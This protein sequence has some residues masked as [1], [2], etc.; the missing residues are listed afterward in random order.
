[1]A[2]QDGNINKNGNN[3]AG[4]NDTDNNDDDSNNNNNSSNNSSRGGSQFE[5]TLD[6]GTELIT[7]YFD[8][9][10]APSP[11]AL[12]PNKEPPP[13][14]CS[15]P[16]PPTCSKPPPSPPP[17]CPA[18]PSCPEP[19][20]SC[21]KPE[22]TCSKPEP[23]CSKLEPT[24]SKPEP[25]CSKAPPSC[26]KK[27]G[28][29]EEKGLFER[30]FEAVPD[31][32][33][34]LGPVPT[35]AC[36]AERFFD[37]ENPQPKKCEK[38]TAK[39]GP[40]KESKNPFAEWFASQ[41]PCPN[42]P[43]LAPHSSCGAVCNA[44]PPPPEP[45]MPYPCCPA[46]APK[47]E[48]SKCANES[49]QPEVKTV[50]GRCSEKSI[51]NEN[52]SAMKIREELEEEEEEEERRGSRERKKKNTSMTTRRNKRKREEE[53]DD[54]DDEGEDEDED[55]RQVRKRKKSLKDTVFGKFLTRNFCGKSE[56]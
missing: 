28:C 13:S 44:E 29:T 51:R 19:Q 32:C 2:M 46:Q 55:E 6:N 40:E 47:P 5:V 25:T 45:P 16:P 18:K 8:D 52:G 48:T 12:C 23:T 37:K 26:P 54:G 22:P 35:D 4:N 17:A 39:C 53:E 41:D 21:S 49:L 3:H 27:Q 9:P 31:K 11:P 36:A 20:P 50:C 33:C 10:S 1:M 14:T 15:Q 43:A 7:R 42:K 30:L 34:D 24:C 56:D 38:P